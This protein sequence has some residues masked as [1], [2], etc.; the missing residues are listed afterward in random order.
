MKK[1]TRTLSNAE[2]LS[3]AAGGIFINLAGAC[4]QF[5]MYFMTN[6]AMLP[7][8]IVGIMLMCGTVFDAVNDPIIGTMADRNQSRMGKY[9]P[10]LILGGLLLCAVS[11]LRF[12]IPD[13]SQGGKICYFMTLLCLYSVGF[14]MCNIPWNTMMSVLSPNYNERNVLLSTKTISSNF[15]GMLV[16]GIMLRSVT[17]LGGD[18]NGGWWKF[19]L[20]GWCIALPFIFICQNGMKRVDYQGS[21][22]NPPKRSFFRGFVHILRHKPVLCL[23][24]GMLLSSIVSSMMNTSELYYYQYVLG[25]MSVLEKT[26][27]LGFPV[28]LCCAVLIPVC[29]KYID[30]RV[31]IIGAFIVCMIKPVFI[32]LFGSGLGTNFVIVLIIISKAGM[33]LQAAAIYAWIPEC[34]DW[35]NYK[36]G[37]ASAGLVNA[38]VTFTMKLG[39]ALGQ[40]AAGGFM[41][42]AGFTAGASVS[43]G[44]I[45]QILN[46][47][48]LYPV[49]GLCLSVVP[50]LF[51]P[52][53]RAKA[54]E[55]REYLVKRDAEKRGDP[56]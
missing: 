47:N 35:T 8:E 16:S 37:A 42:M 55:I 28:T 26:S 11:I 51:F 46:L 15:V 7:A 41:G 20:I 45:T 39:R 30:K 34:V 50:I 1:E 2:I 52:I 32:L 6:V 49:L 25:D 31:A 9:R 5:G 29:L 36:D 56:S 38:S 10:F 48:G 17:A 14:T 40:S 27:F 21:I 23:C 43:E 54:A 33:A 22:P 12:V 44:V 18:E 4:D 3:Y 13:F 19:A 24:L 53:S